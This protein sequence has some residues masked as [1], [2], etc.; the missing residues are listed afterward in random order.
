M[1]Y[2][3]VSIL[4]VCLSSSLF[5]Q[6]PKF[7]LSDQN[8]RAEVLISTIDGAHV[9]ASCVSVGAERIM[10]ISVTNLARAEVGRLRDFSIGFCGPS[11]VGASAQNGWVAKVEGRERHNVTWSLTDDLVDTFGIPSRAR[12]GGF[13]VQ[14]KP[15]WK[16]SRSDSARWGESKITA[17]VTTHDC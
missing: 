17:Q 8:C 11:V 5:G 3:S 9:Y 15:G 1:H 16:R 2:I 6:N 12:V 7:D 13:V 10:H 4:V 14:L